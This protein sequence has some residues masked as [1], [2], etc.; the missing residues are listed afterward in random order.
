M[1][2]TFEVSDTPPPLPR[3]EAP[4]TDST[5]KTG[6]FDPRYPDSTPEAPF[7]YKPDGS[8]YKR[9]HSSHGKSSGGMRLPATSKQAETAAAV[10]G[11]LNGLIALALWANGLKQTAEEMKNANDDF[12][13][14]AAEALAADPA[15]CR[16][17][18]SA[19]TSGAKAGLIMAYGM[20]AI[21]ITPAVVKEMKE[22]KALKEL[23]DDGA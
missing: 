11:K 22:K 6:S 5:L 7:G 23:E 12:M 9:H 2:S 10:L 19:G 13:Q 18:L 4:T 16:K 20:L 14:M 8:P 21:D 1:T 3:D 17:I 15:L